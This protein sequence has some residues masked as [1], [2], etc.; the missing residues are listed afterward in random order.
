LIYLKNLQVLDVLRVILCVQ[1][2][3]VHACFLH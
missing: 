1:T 3:V 2:S